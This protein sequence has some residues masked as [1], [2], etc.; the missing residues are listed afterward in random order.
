MASN[1][2][3]LVGDDGTGGAIGALSTKVGDQGDRLFNQAQTNMNTL[4]GED[5]DAGIIG[6]GF[7]NISDLVNTRADAAATDR[8]TRATALSDQMTESTEALTELAASNQVDNAA[9]QKAILDLI[10]KY[11]GD[12]AQYFADLS[13]NQAGI[14]SDLDTQSD[15]TNFRGAFDRDATL[16]NQ[17]RARLEAANQYQ[18][19]EILRGQAGLQSGQTAGFAAAAN[20]ANDTVE[21][22]QKDFANIAK[23][24]TAGFQTSDATTNSLKTEFQD[25]LA[26]I[27]NA[28]GDENL[29]IDDT[30]R[31]T[32]TDMVN[33]FDATGALIARTSLDNGNFI[34]RAI[35]DTGNLLLAEFNT[36]G[37]RLGQQ[38]ININ[39]MMAQLDSM[40]YVMG[41]NANI[42]GISSLAGFATPY[43][44]TFGG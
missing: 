3:A 25:R 11:G 4:V 8:E 32:Y 41:T 38:S 22:T 37:D 27:R 1:Q 34:S 43:G 29:T 35:D 36:V 13:A 39:R 26:T 19:N 9:Q 16:A 21:Q 14:S 7:T 44:L 24:I 30:I 5:G 42:A 15:L 6:T 20:T 12:A 31:K 18:T 33:S 10:N 17:Q 40:G 28:L 2:A 23:M